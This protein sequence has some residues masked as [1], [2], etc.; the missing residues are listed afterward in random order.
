MPNVRHIFGAIAAALRG[1][2][3]NARR[4]APGTNRARLALESLDPRLSP[5]DLLGT[6]SDPTVIN[7][8]PTVSAITY[9]PVVNVGAAGKAPVID[10]FKGAEIVGGLYRFS[11]EVV[12]AEPCVWTVT[13]GGEPDTLRGM[14]IQTDANGRFSKVLDVKTDKSDDGELSAQAVNAAGVKTEVA[15]TIIYPGR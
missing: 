2:S 10:N 14:Q 5:S 8:D 1:P 7:T 4:P 9:A 11:G 15:L 6:G 13:F 12:G 3:G